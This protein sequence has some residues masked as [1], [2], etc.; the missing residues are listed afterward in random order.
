MNTLF[1][2]SLSLS[3]LS[4]QVHVLHI[5]RRQGQGQGREQGREQGKWEGDELVWSTPRLTGSPQQRHLRLPCGLPGRC[6]R[7]S[8]TYVSIMHYNFFNWMPVHYPTVLISF[9]SSAVRVGEKVIFFGGGARSTNLVSVLHA[10]AVADAETEA[11]FSGRAGP[12]GTK[13]ESSAQEGVQASADEGT[14]SR[15][16]ASRIVINL[17]NKLCTFICT[18]ETSWELQE[19]PRRI[20]CTFPPWLPSEE[21]LLPAQLPLLQG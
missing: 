16:D 15:L 8:S 11:E 10:P 12:A 14:P 17:I 18:K 7:Y 19:Q 3:F 20:S 21:S 1:Y 13:A 6:H 4:V 9:V 2:H 5:V